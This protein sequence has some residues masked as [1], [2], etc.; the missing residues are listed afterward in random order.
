MLKTKQNIN[1]YRLNDLRLLLFELSV[2]GHYPEYVSHI[3]RYWCEQKLSGVL[4]VVV[5]PEF[6]ERHSDVTEIPG[7][8][9]IDNVHFIAITSAERAGLKPYRSGINRTLRA[10]QEFDSIAKYA[11]KLQVEC[12]LIPYFDTKMLPLALGKTLPCSFSGIY[13]RPSF[14]YPYLT[15][16][17][18]PSRKDK[19][20]YLRE[21]IV[22]SRVLENKRLKS[23]LCLDPFAV[24][25]INQIGPEKASYLPDPVKTYPSLSPSQ[26][27]QIAN[28]LG[29]ETSRQI[30]L[31]FG[32][33]NKRKGV[34]Q[35]LKAVPLISPELTQKLCLLFVGSMSGKN[36]HDFQ[37]YK[38]DL[39][40]SL[41]I[42]IIHHNEYIPESDIQN[43]FELADVVL[44]LYQ[45]HVGMSG[46]LNRAAAAQKPVLSS[47]YGLMGEIT[48]RYQLGITVDSSNPHEIANGLSK[49]LTIPPK[50]HINRQ[51]M[52]DYALQNSVDSFA[53]KIFDAL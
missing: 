48:R 2:G 26:L 9:Q 36:F 28:N 16:N 30:H 44:A 46:I 31:I 25:Y 52:S 49:F 5:V 27:K 40:E 33:L 39:C 13:F 37:V 53:S 18:H 42:Q 23:L 6:L 4:N 15:T 38:T 11:R 29:I 47:D 14:H 12:I 41:P 45:R 20:Q 21:K 50:R 35:I 22:L 34:E 7:N 17:Y 19:L 3:V 1:R 10:W 43:Y 24:K 8:Y 32:D 51:K